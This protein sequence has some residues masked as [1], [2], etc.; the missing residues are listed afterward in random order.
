MHWHPAAGSA[1]AALD[2]EG[3]RDVPRGLM[4]VRD[5]RRVAVAQGMILGRHDLD[6]RRIEDVLDRRVEVGIDASKAWESRVSAFTS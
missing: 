5:R 3:R 6:A 1:V 4:L 2:P